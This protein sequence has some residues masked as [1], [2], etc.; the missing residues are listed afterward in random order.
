MEFFKINDKAI[1]CVLNSQELEEQDVR[2]EDMLVGKQ[3]ARDFLNELVIQACTELDMELSTQSLSVHVIPMSGDRLDLLISEIGEQQAAAKESEN[4]SE[5]HLPDSLLSSDRT[6]IPVPSQPPEP[7]VIPEIM[8]KKLFFVVYRFSSL[9]PIIQFAKRILG[10]YCKESSLFKDPRDNYYYLSM[11]EKRKKF[12]GLT[13]L[14]GEYGMLH[15]MDPIMQFS[16]REHY[17][18]ILKEHAIER[19]AKL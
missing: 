17:E 12:R 6:S 11:F 1:R 4:L 10:Q 19:L 9:E 7:P 2:I 5:K 16:L 8:N 14:A 15:S 13:D 3:N 18:I